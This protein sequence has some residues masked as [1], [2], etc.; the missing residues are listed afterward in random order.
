[1]SFGI[2]KLSDLMG[3]LVKV[4]TICIATFVGLFA[5]A[6]VSLLNAMLLYLV[7]YGSDSPRNGYECGRG[8][9]VEF[10]SLFGGGL[11]GACVASYAAI[12]SCTSPTMPGNYGLSLTAPGGRP[13]SSVRT[14][15]S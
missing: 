9:L 10:L 12:R 4:M 3:G 15:D 1:M 11:V 7:I 8:M 5:G 14:G 2:Q 6:L 13:V